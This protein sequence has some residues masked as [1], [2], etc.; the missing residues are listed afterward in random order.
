[1]D[2]GEVLARVARR[3]ER[4]SHK[5]RDERITLAHGA[6]GRASQ[7]L[8]DALFL[9]E[10]S[11]PL[12]APLGDSAVISLPEG[13]RLAF[14][15]DG[16]VVKP[17]SF[18]GGNIGK[19]AVNGTINDLAV[20]GANPIALS[21]AFILEEGL[22]TAALTR[23][24][25]ALGEAAR[26]AGV[27][28]ATADTKVVERGKADGLYICSTGVGLIPDDVSLD[29]RSIRSGDRVLLSGTI[30]DHGMA[31][32]MARGELELEGEIE[33]DTAPLHLLTDALIAA[34]GG[35]LRCMRD[36]T[37]GGLAT[38]VNELARS[39]SVSIVLEE[40]AIPVRGAVAGA[41][42]ILGIDPLYVANEGKLVAIVAADIAD[43]ALEA[44]R[45]DPLGRDAAIV[46]EVR[47]DHA[48]M[49]LLDTEFGGT[50]VVDTLAG[51]PLP[52]IC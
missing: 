34:C 25:A 20:S 51:D 21:V 45:A 46:G 33:S 35:A 27:P 16:Y 8:I 1:M 23:Y 11:N 26:E 9:P 50:R 10:L 13:G 30:G 47:A 18:P 3:R 24:A 42:E 28:V 32:L 40:S 14:T 5:V 49:V 12:L 6:G 43:R 36:P 19:L 44:L 2:E 39:A 4:T 29:A 15:T 41:C 17:L 31:V 38:T 37:R 22:E 48:G 7:A 52:R